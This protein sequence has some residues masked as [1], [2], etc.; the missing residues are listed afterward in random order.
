MKALLLA[1]VLVFWQ[2]AE[3]SVLRSWKLTAG[4]IAND[5]NVDVGKEVD[6]DGSSGKKPY[7]ISIDFAENSAGYKVTLTFDDRDCK[8]SIYDV[9]AKYGFSKD[10]TNDGIHYG[11]AFMNAL[12]ENRIGPDEIIIQLEGASFQSQVRQD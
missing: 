9:T 1:I 4:D 2:R 7:H 6:V 8:G 12:I 11:G 10:S 3:M 5:G